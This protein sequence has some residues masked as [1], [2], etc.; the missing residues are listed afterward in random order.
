[1]KKIEFHKTLVVGIG[2]SFLIYIGSMFLPMFNN[3]HDS[4]GIMGFMLGWT[5]YVDSKPIMAISWT[6]NVTFLLSILIYTMSIKG[7]FILSLGT[8]CL[9]LVAL[10]YEEFLF[11]KEGNIPGIGFFVWI[12]S[13]LT[14]ITTFYIRLRQEKP[15]L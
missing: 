6:A 13:F 2:I 11:G 4:Y 5:G 15:L 1:M 10:G 9:A 12:F 3:D 14:M 7:R 8:L